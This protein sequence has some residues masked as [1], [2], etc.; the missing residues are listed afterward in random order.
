MVAQGRSL[1]SPKAPLGPTGP[2]VPFE[3]LPIWTVGFWGAHFPFLFTWMH[4]SWL[5]PP[6]FTADSC[7]LA[8]TCRSLGVGQEGG[9]ESVIT[10]PKWAFLGGALH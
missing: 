10:E 9:E 7:L 8:K 5:R 3:T 1:A 6:A 4:S 2:V